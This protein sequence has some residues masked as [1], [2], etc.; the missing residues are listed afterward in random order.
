MCGCGAS[1][2]SGGRMR[3]FCTKPPI[4]SQ[5]IEITKTM[6]ISQKSPFR[7][8]PQA[9]ERKQSLL[10]DGIRHAAEIADLAYT[11]L[12]GTLTIIALE[13][14]TGEA[15]RSELVTSV[16]L[17][18]WAFVDAIDRFR[19]IYDTTVTYSTMGVGSFDRQSFNATFQPIRYLRNVADHLAERIDYILSKNGTALGVLSWV[20]VLDTEQFEWASC[21]IVP[22]S[23]HQISRKNL[24]V[25]PMNKLG[26]LPTGQVHLAAGGHCA[27]LSDFLPEVEARVRILENELERFITENELH[28][29]LAGSDILISIFGN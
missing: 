20:T 29:N 8:L 24:A 21:M 26:D 19:L 17:D 15:L 12:N 28:Q 23:T 14:H 3:L 9:L 6:I 18:C 25:H 27:C 22:G 4:R 1:V 13:N 7:Q 16:F 11:R 5:L 2:R 10:F